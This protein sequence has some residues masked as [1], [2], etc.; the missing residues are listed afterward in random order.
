MSGH[1]CLP[2]L[3]M[4]R[5]KPPRPLLL[6][7]LLAALSLPPGTRAFAGEDLGTMM[8][9]MRAMMQMWNMYNALSGGGGGRGEAPWNLLGGGGLPWSGMEGY[10][11]I[12]AP[13]FAREFRGPGASTP[14]PEDRLAG[15][16]QGS[17]GELFQA[18]GD[19]FRLLGPEGR[20][21]EGRFLLHG[22]R[23]VVYLPDG[24]QVLLYEFEQHG[25]AFALRDAYGQ[26]TLFQR[27]GGGSPR[28]WAGF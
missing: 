14:A 3:P 27:R 25:A 5:R 24:D 23:L 15:V 19:W 6:S 1:S 28:P 4:A 7:V 12:P 13:P 22:R 26:I 16:W 11:P 9:G 8:Q 20:G 18:R 21:V 2:T 10:G 17:N